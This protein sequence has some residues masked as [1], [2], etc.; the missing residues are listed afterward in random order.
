MLPDGFDVVILSRKR[1]DT[2]PKQTL[3]LMPWAT[4][5]V[6]ESE[7]DDYL[8]ILPRE[9]LLPHPTFPTMADLRNW[10]LERSKDAEFHVQVHDD[11]KALRCLVGWRARQYTDPAIIAAVIER[12]AICARDAGCG[13]FGFGNLQGGGAYYSPFKPFKLN[14]YIRNVIGYVRGHGLTWDPE[15]MGHY[16]VDVS[17]SSLLKHRITWRDERW[18]FTDAPLASNRGG[19]AGIRTAESLKEG[20]ENLIGKWGAHVRFQARSDR[21]S[22]GQSRTEATVIN[23]RRR[24]PRL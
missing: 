2:L 1:S 9:Q 7:M 23:V 18:T 16:D 10:L 4:V 11:L 21:V 24:D 20:R 6:D 13:M 12:T 15:M 19:F 14:R 17:L 3:R 8:K 5:T 22:K